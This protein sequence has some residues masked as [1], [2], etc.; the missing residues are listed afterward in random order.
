[1]FVTIYFFSESVHY[2]SQNSFVWFKHVLK[3]LWGELRGKFT[4][5]F[6]KWAQQALLHV[7]A[8]LIP[9]DSKKGEQRCCCCL[10]TDLLPIHLKNWSHSQRRLQ[11]ENFYRIHSFHRGRSMLQQSLRWTDLAWGQV[12]EEAKESITSLLLI[13]SAP[14]LSVHHCGVN[15]CEHQQH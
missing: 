12:Q 7:E 8:M 1:M 10:F 4:F 5:R 14:H 11:V 13:M 2:L 6:C 15:N 9:D 3:Y